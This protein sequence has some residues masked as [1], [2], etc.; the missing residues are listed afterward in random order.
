[1]LRRIWAA[2]LVA[3]AMLICVLHAVGQTTAPGDSEKKSGTAAPATAAAEQKWKRW[4]EFDQL[5]IATRYH[6]IKNANHVTAANNQQYQVQAR[7]HFK[8]DRKGRYAVHAGLFSGNSFNGG[9]NN[10]NLGTGHYQTN[11]FLK[12]LYFAAKPVKAVEFQIGGLAIN[13]GENSEAIGYDQ[14]G[15]ITGERVSIRNPKTLYFDE[16]SV[17]SARLGELNRPS[18]FRRAKHF[19]NQNYHQILVRKQ[20]NKFVGVSADYTFESGTD[21]LRQAVRVKT[22]KSKYLHLFLFE[23]YERLDPDL[24]YGF[25]VY[26]ERKLEKHFALGVGFAHVDRV[27]LNGDRYPRGNRLYAN[28]IVTFNKEFTLT[29][30]FTESVGPVLPNLVRTRLDVTLNY[31]FLETMRRLKIY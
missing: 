24:G 26:G 21:A 1:M 5:S 23:N 9:W 20:V 29:T 14:D 28:G 10:T 15:Y 17:T 31:N 8:F 25:N 7:A 4:L 27:M 11:L 3:S 6:Y 13:N 12:Q 18:I 19:D 30:S 22:P 2:F 16:I